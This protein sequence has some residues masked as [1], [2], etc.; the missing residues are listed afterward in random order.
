MGAQWPPIF[1]P[2]DPSEA[3]F[4]WRPN[5]ERACGRLVC[6]A[7]YLYGSS[8]VSFTI[9]GSANGTI[10]EA[11]GLDVETRA[12]L[13]QRSFREVLRVLQAQMDVQQTLVS[14]DTTWGDLMRKRSDLHPNTPKVEVGI[15]NDQTVVFLPDQPEYGLRQQTLV[16]VNE[17]D[18]LHN[19]REKDVLAVDW[20]TKIRQRFSQTLWERSFDQQF[21]WVR[22]LVAIAIVTL[23]ILLTILIEYG[24]RWLRRRSRTLKKRLE[25]SEQEL[26][27]SMTVDP[28][29]ITP[30]TLQPPA[31]PSAQLAPPSQAHPIFNPLIAV[32]EASQSVNHLFS[33]FSKSFLKEQTLLKQQRNLL[34][35][36]G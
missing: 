17:F 5:A 19:G 10:P 26:K 12:Q 33:I 18:A 28:E 6:S 27:K 1:A 16:T 2:P 22:P 15:E 11:S 32:S 13:V 20:Q 4:G 35:L 29:S 23:A 25:A 9:A 30:D 21:P 24:R 14:V 36:H 3:V 8:G 34:Q 7:V 31:D